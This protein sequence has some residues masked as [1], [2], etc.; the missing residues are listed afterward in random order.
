MYKVLDKGEENIE[1]TTSYLWVAKNLI[2]EKG[3]RQIRKCIKIIPAKNIILKENKL[4]IE[5][6]RSCIPAKLVPLYTCYLNL[7]AKRAIFLF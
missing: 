6:H 7:N 5:D 4:S 2:G 3:H 1:V